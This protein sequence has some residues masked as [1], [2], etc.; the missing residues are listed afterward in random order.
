LR[1]FGLGDGVIGLE[2]KNMT[3]ADLRELESALPN[4]TFIGVDK[5]LSANRVQKTDA[6]IELI[7]RAAHAAETAMVDAIAEGW[8]G[9]TEREFSALLRGACIRNGADEVAWLALQWGRFDQFTVPTDEPIKAGE[10]FIIEMGVTVE[11]YLADVQRTV[12]AGPVDP[13][14]ADVYARLAQ[15]HRRTLESMSPGKKFAAVNEEFLADMAA[16]DLVMWD[17]FHLGH[18]LGLD[19]HE[20]A[21]ITEREESEIPSN[22]TY[23]LEPVVVQPRLVGIE[24]V[25]VVRDEGTS[26]LSWSVDWSK[27][28]ELGTRLA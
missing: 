24:D 12:A 25:V 6:E 17:G 20:G 1:K 16:N 15:V 28:P 11:G 27:I 13:V 3:A 21:N 2:L 22:S 5:D 19:A 18:G 7:A 23:S 9:M 10:T 14:T 26:I 4:A 8:V